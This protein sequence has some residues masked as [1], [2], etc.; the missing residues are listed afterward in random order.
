MLGDNH[1]DIIWRHFGIKQGEMEMVKS[2]DV[3][4]G[5]F[6][7]ICSLFIIL[8]LRPTNKTTKSW[9]HNTTHDPARVL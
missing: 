7:L 9:N 1:V 3:T 6:F 2:G 5:L 4:E 8:T